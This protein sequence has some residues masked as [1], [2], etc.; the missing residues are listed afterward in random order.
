MLSKF[1]RVLNDRNYSKII[2]R[3]ILKT[4]RDPKAA[5]YVACQIYIR[6]YEGFSYDFEKNGEAYVLNSLKSFLNNGVVYDVGANRGDWSYMFASKFPNMSIYSFEPSPL[7]FK[8]YLIPRTSDISSINAFNKGMGSINNTL[9]FKEY[10]GGDAFSTF[11]LESDYHS[12]Q[13]STISVEVVTGDTFS[14][15]N[16]IESIDYLKID[17]EGFEFEVLKGFG[18]MLSEKAIKII[19][20][21]Y[22]YANAD[23]GHTLKDIYNF[24]TSKGYLVGPIKPEGVIFMEF[25]YPLNNFT[26]GPNF[27]AVSSEEHDLIKLL[28]GPP[29]R[30]YPYNK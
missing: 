26:S 30:F 21:E 24:L 18:N 2:F 17:V 23:A 1:I 25:D 19:Q 20:F 12:L 6:R 27:I 7:T 16:K 5:L 9:P 15:T 28:E 4:L 13:T 14:E 11:I 29:I 22:G 10:I 8:K 3:K